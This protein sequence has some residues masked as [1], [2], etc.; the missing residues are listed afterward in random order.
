MVGTANVYESTP[1]GGG[2]GL[3][4]KGAEFFALV[5]F[6]PLILFLIFY[7]PPYLFLIQTYCANKIPAAPETIAPVR[8]A[9]QR[10]A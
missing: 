10:Y 4:L 1:K 8:L 3:P 2:F 7:I 5:L 9:L 6:E